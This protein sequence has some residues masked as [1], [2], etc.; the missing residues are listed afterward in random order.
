M[1]L[2]KVGQTP[3][4]HECQKEHRPQRCLNFTWSTH[5]MSITN[6]K[7]RNGWE[8]KLNRGRHEGSS[9]AAACV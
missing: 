6:E 4:Q 9:L 3:R 5:S 1:G 8:T 7:V 2:E